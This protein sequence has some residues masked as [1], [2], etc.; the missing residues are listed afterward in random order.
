MLLLDLSIVFFIFAI[1]PFVTYPLTLWV[2]K[3]FFYRVSVNEKPP[4]HASSMALCF[5]AYNEEAI[6]DDKIE[7]LKAIKQQNPSLQIYVYADACTDR[8]AEILKQHAEL[9]T[10][11]ISNKR[12]GKTAGMNKLVSMIQSDIIVFTDANVLL[13]PNTIGKIPNYFTDPEVG[14]V[15]GHL[16][17][18][19]D[20][21]STAEVGSAYWRLEE[22]IKQLEHDTGSVMGADGS[23]FAIRRNL[24]QPVPNDI[25]DD[26]YLS[27]RILCDG[28]RIV[29]GGDI[30]AFEKSA[31]SSKDEFA[32]KIRIACQAVNVHRL[33]WP[34]LKQLGWWNLYKYISHKFI[35]W[36]CV[37]WLLSASFCLTAWLIITD[38]SF[39]AVIIWLSIIS[40]SA[41]A[42]LP[43]VK[44]L[45]KFMDLFMAFAATGIGVIHSVRGETFQTWEPSSSVRSND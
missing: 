26:M 24:H 27:L 43:N 40:A 39:A 4:L 5:C 2:A 30:G 9:L 8:T 19:N 16:K 44:P 23:I 42:R 17:Y 32:R 38:L 25:I 33:L 36:L 1:H 11:E 3:R 6:L 10:L 12:T 31:S 13:D 15:C 22:T 20:E 7:N 28:Y 18:I 34:H 21:S 35:R 41:L 14:C 45:T 37:F 29:R